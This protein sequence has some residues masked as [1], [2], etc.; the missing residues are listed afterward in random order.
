MSEKLALLIA[1]FS[2]VATA[3][4]ALATWNAPRAAAKLAESLRRDAERHNERQRQKLA[5][6][7][8]LMQERAQIYSDNAVRALNLI[9]LVF[10]ESRQV[11]EAWS[12]L[13]LAF[14]MNPLLQH[15]IDERLRKLL[16][17]IA[18]DIGLADELRND[19]LGRVYF[20]RAQQ[21]EQFIKDMQRQQIIAS[22]QGQSAAGATIPGLQT[23]W[24]PKPE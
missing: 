17:A 1:I 5:L 21:Q 19:D 22:L 23:A 18:K 2:A 11:R 9:D 10:N 6:L 16:A 15:V 24:P 13:F 4:A 20:P 7:G 3:F 14:H 12:E 8:T